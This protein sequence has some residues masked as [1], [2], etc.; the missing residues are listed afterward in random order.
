MLAHLAQATWPAAA[1]LQRASSCAPPVVQLR[2]RLRHAFPGGP[3]KQST[4]VHASIARVLTPRQL[5]GEEIAR[6][7]VRTCGAVQACAGGA[8]CLADMPPRPRT[9]PAECPPAGGVRQVD[10]AAAGP[11]VQ[12]R[13][14]QPHPGKGPWLRARPAARAVVAA[15]AALP[16]RGPCWEG[17]RAC[18]NEPAPSHRPWPSPHCPCRSTPS[19]L[20]RGRAFHCL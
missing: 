14:H 16:L 3:P 5:S 12:P 4:I 18:V 17:V 15:G 10:G 13:P 7:Q 1:D 8:V 20:W 2:K 11:A 6:V 9:L 19:P